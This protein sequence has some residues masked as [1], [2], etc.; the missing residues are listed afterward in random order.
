MEG[1]IGYQPSASQFL[2]TKAAG[3]DPGWTRGGIEMLGKGADFIS[4]SQRTLDN[5]GL[6]MATLEAAA[7]P[8]SQ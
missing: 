5:P 8:V 1:T 4:K 6:N 3:M 2:K 7:V